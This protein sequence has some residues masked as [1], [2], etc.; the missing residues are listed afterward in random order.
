MVVAVV[1]DDGG[2][3]IV[4]FLPIV[5]EEKL[6]V[7]DPIVAEVVLLVVGELLL[8]DLFC[9][10]VPIEFSYLQLLP[11]Y[12]SSLLQQFSLKAWWWINGE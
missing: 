1:G 9:I 5:V 3:A 11:W 2:G 8:L 6:R 12:E 4:V 7:Q 10:A